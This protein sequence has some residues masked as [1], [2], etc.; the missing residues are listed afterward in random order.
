MIILPYFLSNG[1]GSGG[2]GGGWGRT[3]KGVI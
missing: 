1:V 2:G 3:I